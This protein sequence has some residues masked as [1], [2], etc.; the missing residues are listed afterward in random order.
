MAQVTE[1][2]SALNTVA[3]NNSQDVTANGLSKGPKYITVD[4]GQSEYM[5]SHE[6]ANL[7]WCKE[8]WAGMGN[9]QLLSVKVV[10]QTTDKAQSIMA[11]LCESSANPD[12]TSV[13]GY[14]SRFRFTSNMAN[15]G[16]TVE[17]TL[18]VPDGV[19]TQVKPP[20]AVQTIPK[21][22]L[23]KGAGFPASLIIYYD[24]FGPLI[25]RFKVEEV[26]TVS[27]NVSSQART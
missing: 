21:L 18:S 2:S 9:V 13:L 10:F 3:V 14:S 6:F 17:M 22:F 24:Y 15:C 16:S 25:R 1:Q 7:S 8:S 11:C 5:I 27:G 19:S 26:T 20:S 12:E 23:K 4:L